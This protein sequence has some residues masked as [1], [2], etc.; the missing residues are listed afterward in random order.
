MQ[1]DEKWWWQTQ[2]LIFTTRPAIRFTLFM[3]EIIK[4]VDKA[5]DQTHQGECGDKI[6]QQTYAKKKNVSPVINAKQLDF[7][8]TRFHCKQMDSAE[9]MA[10]IKQH[11][12][13]SVGSW[14]TCEI[15]FQKTAGIVVSWWKIGSQ[16]TQTGSGGVF[17]NNWIGNRDFSNDSPPDRPHLTRF[18]FF[19]ARLIGRVGFVKM[20][21]FRKPNWDSLNWHRV[22][23]L[24]NVESCR[25]TRKRN[26]LS[27][28]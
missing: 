26:G 6:L 17:T 16:L 21:M 11:Q 23:T 22:Q 3:V 1:Y 15:Y 9:K 2:L 14:T 4:E 13:K 19:R 10:S 24:L 28:I 20:G 8:V 18:F 7:F 27:M 25:Y 5:I 12:K